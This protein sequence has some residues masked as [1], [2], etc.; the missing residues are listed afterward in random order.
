MELDASS[1]AEFQNRIQT[2]TAGLA[3]L[4][5]FPVVPAYHGPPKTKRGPRPRILVTAAGDPVSV[6]SSPSCSSI[7]KHE[8]FQRFAFA[9]EE[10]TRRKTGLE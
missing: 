6:S 7:S 5:T 4:A 1:G 8:A 2:H 3:S 10:G 9:T